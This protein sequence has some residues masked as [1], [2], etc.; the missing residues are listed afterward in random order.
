MTNPEIPGMTRDTHP[1]NP[2][3]QYAN[4][5]FPIGAA[6]TVAYGSNERPYC[7]LGNLYRILGHLDQ[8]V[9]GPEDI[10]DRIIANAD[11]VRAA[12]PDELRVTET[13]PRD[14][15][16]TAAIAWVASMANK[17]GPTVTIPDLDLTGYTATEGTADDD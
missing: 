13:P 9:P 15:N 5:V 10:N 11:R 1:D 17:Y 16:E 14:D 12:L 6:L 4:N 7:T 8:H 3:Q 2:V